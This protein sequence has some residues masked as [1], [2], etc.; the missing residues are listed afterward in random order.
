MH[1]LSTTQED[2]G[3]RREPAELD[4]MILHALCIQMTAMLVISIIYN[5]CLW[6]WILVS[7]LYLLKVIFSTICHSHALLLPRCTT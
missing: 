6:N 3:V 7:I 5:Y 1:S 2:E 4:G